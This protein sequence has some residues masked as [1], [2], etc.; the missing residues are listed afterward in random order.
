MTKSKEKNNSDKNSS[1]NENNKRKTQNSLM[2][3]IAI[4]I[5]GFIVGGAIIYSN[6]SNSV[7]G[8]NLAQV[9]EGVG[10]GAAQQPT[11]GTG[12]QPSNV[13]AL[14]Q[15][16]QQQAPQP[17][18]YGRYVALAE[19]LGFNKGEFEQ[20]INEFDS[21]EVKADFDYAQSIGASGTPTFFIGLNKGDSVEAIK[22]V[23]AQPLANFKTALDTLL[24]TGDLKAT[25]E[26]IQSQDGSTV[27]TVK[28]EGDPSKGNANAKVAIV[29]FSDYE[30]PFCKRYYNDTYKALVSEYVD[31]NK[32]QYV[33][34]DLPLT[35]HDPVATESAVAANCARAQGGDEAYFRYHDAIFERTQTNGRGI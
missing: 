5:A 30:C 31:T 20:C 8:N 19:E 18:G 7:G 6:Q 24:N 32:I 10:G 12:A 11:G 16:Q 25:A 35:F 28:K 29:E 22:I 4:V 34:R 26:S 1:L 17:Q 23:G 9:V 27:I 3:P 14:Q 21:A 13:A 2:T 33:F 15:A